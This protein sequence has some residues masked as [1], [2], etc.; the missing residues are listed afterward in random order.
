MEFNLFFVVI[1]IY[2]VAQFSRVG[3]S[4]AIVPRLHF[5]AGPNRV[6]NGGDDENSKCHPEHDS[7]FGEWWL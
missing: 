6:D 2:D 7:P 4:I 1:I 5:S 3:F